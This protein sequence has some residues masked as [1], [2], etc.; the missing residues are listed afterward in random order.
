MSKPEMYS[1]QFNNTDTP[2]P[3]CYDYIMEE[4]MSVLTAGQRKYA[5]RL[6]K[7]YTGWRSFAEMCRHYPTLLTSRKGNSKAAKLE[8]MRMQHLREFYAIVTGRPAFGLS[9][10]I[11]GL[12]P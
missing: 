1:Y 6:I 4:R 11:E 8:R 10:H 7:E 3:L 2:V 12:N 9:F 5:E